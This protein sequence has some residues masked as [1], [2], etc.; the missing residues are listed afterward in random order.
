MPKRKQR[1]LIRPGEPTQRTPTGLE[2]PV[3]T[4]EEVEAVFR[5]VLRKQAPEPSSVPDPASR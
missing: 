1:P 4:R 5:K 2:I 3:P